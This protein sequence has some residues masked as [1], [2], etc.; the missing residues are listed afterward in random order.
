MDAVHHLSIDIE[1]Y[2][3]VDIGK[4]GLYKY[5]QSPAFQILLIAYSLD[6]GPVEVI[7]LASGGMSSCIP[8][9]LINALK[10]PAYIKHA[11]NAA[12]EWYCLCRHFRWNPEKEGAA[13][14]RQWRCTMLHGL[15][16]GYTAGLDA[17]GKALGLPQDKQKLATGKALIKYFCIPCAPSKTNGGRTRNL[18]HHDPGK[19]E[20]FKAYNAQDV[21]TEMEIEHRLSRFPVPEE[22][23]AQWVTDQIIN[24]RGVAV[25]RAMVEG[26]LD[27]DAAV[28]QEYLQEA[29]RLSGL[30]NPN[31]VAQLTAW[32]QEETGEEVA[33]LRKTTVSD[34]LGK[35]LSSESARRML[36][37]RQELGKTSNKKYNALEAAV[38][39]DGRVR[40]LLQF[41]GANRTG[42]WAGRIVQ[43]QN[44]PR[45][46]IDGDLLPMARQ[47]VESRQR[48]ALQVI[49]GSVPDTLSQLIR[50]AF[51]ASPGH[52]LVDADFS[53]I[54]ARVIA[55]LAGEEW[56]LDVFRTHGK[57]YEATA[58][59]MFNIPLERIKKG[60]PEYSYRQKGKVATLALGYQGGTGS[61]V[62]MG[63]L[64]NGL[65]E[66]EL[67]DIVD[68]WRNA[69]PN[70]VNFWYTVD[71]AAREAVNT[72]RCIGLWDGR[73]A[74]ARE[75]D[76]DNDLDFLTIRLPSGRKLYYAKP[77]M[78]VNRFGQPSLGY[79][80][81][82]QKT[83]K[84]ERLETYG[85]KLVENITQA[86]ARDCLAEAIDRLEAAGYPVVFHIHDE[87]VID[88][89]PD[90]ADLDDVIRIMSQVPSWA[91]GLPLNADG[92]VNDFFKKD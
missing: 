48:G 78:G 55:W 24:L 9:W 23:Q 47:L 70:I 74:F 21:V 89:G 60:S 14:L 45:T 79:W 40:G 57:I 34:L 26:A 49:F 17:T 1:T 39:A 69:N 83:K 18:P 33:D 75:S 8:L 71:A 12:F 56:V 51:T 3:D 36:E 84:W 87:V 72:G 37:I 30:D 90:K 73:L 20:L 10:D 86:V 82:N 31:S 63:A 13:F 52:T 2:S 38:C 5:A 54:E 7:D 25:D 15:Y 88:A 85:G 19:W 58:S 92:W 59:Q 28:R 29:M 43:P 16:C 41:Y 62:S 50:T 53:A 68:R 66:E 65:T 6:G 76:P 67:P 77:H 32:L 64:R 42:R 46:Y 35:D 4:A 91:G 80:G 44:L 81:M 22:V 27:L 61:L 11:Y